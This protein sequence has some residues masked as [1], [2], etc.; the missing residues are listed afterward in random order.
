MILSNKENYPFGMIQP[1]RTWESDKYRY[2]FNSFEKDDEVKGVGNHI[3]F[4]DYGYDTRLGRRW[5][6]DPASLEY[7]NISHYAFA[8]NSPIINK[9]PDGKRIRPLNAA[10]MRAF[11]I[12]LN[13]YGSEPQLMEA[14]NMGFNPS[15]GTFY[16][17]DLSPLSRRGFN[18]RLREQGIRLNRE[19]RENAYTTYLA[20]VDNE[21]IQI[22]VI[23]AGSSTT[24]SPDGGGTRVEGEGIRLNASE[25]LNRVKEDI[26][27]VGEATEN[28]INDAVRPSGGA[29]TGRYRPDKIG[30]NYSF[31]NSDP[32][33]DERNYFN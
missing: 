30:E 33:A 23:S 18:R 24:L 3:S 28:I 22:E 5:Q 4:G 6:I 25:G 20:V 17:F 27:R 15:N 32:Q 10:A 26:I 21:E 2:G 12:L 13:S 19:D 9:D 11:I 14:F 16:S 8:A 1:E 29:G 31:Y 7:P